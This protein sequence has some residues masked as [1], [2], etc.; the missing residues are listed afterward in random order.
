MTYEKYTDEQLIELLRAGDAAVEDFLMN[1]YKSL[2]RSRAR[3]LYLEGGDT[4]DLL[5]EG[6][7]GLFKAI[8]EYDPEKEA[9][10]R[11]FAELCM[12]RQM[13]TAISKA[14]QKKHEMLN[15]YVSLSE[16]EEG[17]EAFAP[18]PG[19]EELVV[20][21]AGA[22]ELLEKIKKTLSPMETRVLDLYLS[23]MDYHE[24]AA[25]LQKS[26]KSIDNALQRIRAKARLLIFP[27]QKSPREGTSPDSRSI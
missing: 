5:Q 9:S 27:S 1:K 17:T 8:R 7:W 10:F 23:G 19:P 24:I 26:D 21:R 25:R 15:K 12:T 4:E 16:D 18:T 13:Y 11:T 20:D 22:D 14:S 2:V 6:M 3:T